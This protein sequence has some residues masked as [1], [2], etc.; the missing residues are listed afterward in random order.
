MNL[1]LKRQIFH[2]VFG[3]VSVILIYFDYINLKFFFCLLFVSLVVSFIHSKKQIKI[4]KWFLDRFDRENVLIPGKGAIT[5]LAGIVLSLLLFDKNVALAGL[6]ILSL[7]D[8]FSHLG[9][10]GRFRHPFNENKFIEGILLGILVGG[11][12]ASFFVGGL[13]AF[14]G[15]T[16][17]MIFE[18]FEII[19]LKRKLDDN[20]LIPLIAGVVMS[21]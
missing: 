5:F 11:A 2:A 13:I 19:I 20:I 3:I 15:A 10:F 1:E 7:G 12:G 4:I 16:I 6:V 18:S 8:S 9:R 21:I 14:F 17:A